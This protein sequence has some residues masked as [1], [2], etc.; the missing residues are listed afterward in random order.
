MATL[1]LP[2]TNRS[3][4][5]VLPKRTIAGDLPVRLVDPAILTMTDFTREYPVTIDEEEDIESALAEMIRLGVRAMMVVKGQNVVGFISSYDIQGER[6]I[7]YLLRSSQTRHQDIQVGH[8]M[9]PWSE[10]P[11]IEWRS[12]K[13]AC[14]G[15]L[16]EAF[17]VTEATHLLV[18]EIMPNAVSEVRG[19]ISRT[20]LDRQLGALSAKSA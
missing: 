8:I 6:P 14:V 3:L 7:Q 5:G 13:N 19:L 20:R 10:V 16:V 18:L 17:H 11:A 2:N 9:T 1:L 4:V 15:D 12:V